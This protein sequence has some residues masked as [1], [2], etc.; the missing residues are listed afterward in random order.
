LSYCTD[1][2]PAAFAAGLFFGFVVAA[3]VGPIWLLCARS[4]I[5]HGFPSGWAIGAGA[6]IVDL[7]YAALGVAGVG[8]LLGLT[9]LR[10]VL[11]LAG[12]VVLVVL[13]LRTLASAF[14][15]RLGLETAG[16]V[17]SPRRA[18][19]TSLAATAS[20]PMTIASW[21]AVFAAAS[22]AEVASSVP[23]AALLV[24]GVGIG[25]LA[26]FTLLALLMSRLRTRI[27]E[28]GLRAVDAGAGIGIAGFGGFLGYH[29]LTAR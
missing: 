25:S 18:F 10:L 15:V 22:G 24:A 1:D 27:G 7:S 8:A 20:N 6:A 17:A 29:A 11:G 28:R 12:A 19:L 4:S 26:W 5:R 9:G 16:E 14:R 2:V 13:G 3:G 21:G 23:A